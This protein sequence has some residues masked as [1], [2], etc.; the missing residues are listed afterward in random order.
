MDFDLSADQK[1]IKDVARE[2][3]AARSPWAKVREAA[4]A[5]EYGDALWREVGELGWPGIAV[6][7][8]HGGQGL[9]AVEL[10]VL[11]EELGYACAA[12]PFLSAA[13]AA[14]VIQACGTDEQRARHLAALA[15]GEATA[16]VG[17][18]ELGADG[19]GAA[20]AVLPARGAAQLGAGGV[21]G[22]GRGGRGVGG[23]G[24]GGPAGRAVSPPPLRG[25]PR[26]PRR[27]ARPGGR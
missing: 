8:E 4:E 22:G 13:V 5:R 18:R 14:S 12:L 1:E 20:V 2:L 24:G 19:V 23:G 3:L 7:E 6:A 10:A 26:R 17:T 15:A 25:G 16:G 9:G 27:A 11:L 21:L